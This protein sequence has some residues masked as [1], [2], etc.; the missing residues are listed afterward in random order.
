MFLPSHYETS[1]CCRSLPQYLRS[2]FEPAHIFM[3]LYQ[4]KKFAGDK[5]VWLGLL[6]DSDRQYFWAS[7]ADLDFT[8]WAQGQ[9]LSLN[10][11]MRL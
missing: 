5:G 8:N 9:L 10:V 1:C 7:G 2:D 4:V 3:I 6:L 11:M